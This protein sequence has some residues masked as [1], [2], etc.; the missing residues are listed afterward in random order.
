MTDKSAD[1]SIERFPV[2]FDGAGD[3][4]NKWDQFDYVVWI[5]RKV[6]A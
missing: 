4:G 5:S 2:Y 1:P 3:K 6:T